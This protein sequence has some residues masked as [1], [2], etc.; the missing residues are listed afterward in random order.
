LKTTFFVLDGGDEF[1]QVSEI[2]KVSHTPVYRK[3]RNTVTIRLARED[4]VVNAVKESTG[5]FFPIP[6]DEE[7]ILITR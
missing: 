4:V 1:I 2:D 6:R 5:E 3:L 7:V